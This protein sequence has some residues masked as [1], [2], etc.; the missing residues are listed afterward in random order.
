MHR[1]NQAK[2]FTSV[3][4]LIGRWFRENI[5]LKAFSCRSRR[6]AERTMHT[7]ICTCA[8][9]VGM[10]PLL[11]TKK[12]R[13]IPINPLLRTTNPPLRI[14]NC[15]LRTLIAICQVQI[16]CYAN[17]ACSYAVRQARLQSFVKPGFLCFQQVICLVNVANLS[18]GTG[19]RQK[20]D[21]T[22]TRRVMEYK[23]F[24]RTRVRA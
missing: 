21:L 12:I 20:W 14:I 17:V 11:R 9:T 19:V 16:E 18:E 22:C 24:V 5:S 13:L 6:T 1:I 2:G 8:C 15:L 10:I 4:L 3:L 23:Y 7:C